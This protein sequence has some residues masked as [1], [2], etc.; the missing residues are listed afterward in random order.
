MNI[1]MVMRS[2]PI[3]CFRLNM[4]LWQAGWWFQICFMTSHW[5]GNGT[6]I[7]TDFNSI[8]CQRG[9]VETTNQIYLIN[10][11][12]DQHGSTIGC[13]VPRPRLDETSMVSSRWRERHKFGLIV[14][15]GAKTG[16]LWESA[17]LG[18]K[19]LQTACNREFHMELCSS[20]LE[21]G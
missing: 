18:N 4:G 13:A 9:M 1:E 5:V 20:G 2:A 6:I 10:Q 7:P 15:G 3:P 14:R 16:L 11:P 8:I 21:I 19:R 12:M 17:K